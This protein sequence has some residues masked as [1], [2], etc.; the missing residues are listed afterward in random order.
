MRASGVRAFIDPTT[1]ELTTNPSPEQLRRM[2]LASRASL[3]RSMV[4]LRPFALARGGRGV[5]LEGRFDSAY[6]VEIGK[7][8]TFHMTC[9]DPAHAETPHSHDAD[10]AVLS[11]PNADASAPTAAADRAVTR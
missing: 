5:N 4:G 8:G 9:G 3:S 7:D 10:T 6:R 11:T 2:A 1:G